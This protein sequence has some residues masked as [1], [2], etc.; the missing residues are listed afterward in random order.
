M[1]NQL[2]KLGL[3]CQSCTARRAT[4]MALSS[5]SSRCKLE[6][7]LFVMVCCDVVFLIIQDLIGTMFSP[8]DQF[9]GWVVSKTTFP[10][11]GLGDYKWAYPKAA[12]FCQSRSA[13]CFLHLNLILL[14]DRSKL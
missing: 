13:G 12:F 2:C 9:L 10:Y 7:P 8:I 14:R 5:V 11:P 1:V 3:G 6:L 4:S